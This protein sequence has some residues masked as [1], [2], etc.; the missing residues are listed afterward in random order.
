MSARPK[1]GALVSML[2]E[3]FST[4]ASSISR[5]SMSDTAVHPNGS[6]ISRKHLPIHNQLFENG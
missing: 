3:I 5:S 2:S 4:P 1:R 6:N